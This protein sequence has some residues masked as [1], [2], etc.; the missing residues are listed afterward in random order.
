MTAID[1]APM[2][3]R[4]DF[5]F[6]PQKNWMNDPN[7]LVYFE[8]EYHLFFQ[9]NPHGKDWGHMSWG[10]AVS[11][12]LVYWQELPIAMPERE[13]MIFSGSVVV[14]WSNSSGLGDGSAPP[15][16]A[17]YTAYWQTSE[18]QSQHLAYSHDRG[19]TWIEYPGNPVLCLEMEHFRDPKV[20]W[21]APSDAWVLVVALSREHKVQV[22]RSTDLIVWDLASEF[23]PAGSTS[24]QWECPDLIEVPIE[25]TSE[26]A[27]A[28][29]VDVDKDLV[30]GGSGA[31]VFAGAFDGYNFTPFPGQ[32]A[33][34]VDLGPDFYAAQSWSD[35][36]EGTSHPI[37]IGWMSN[38]LTGKDYPTHPWRGAMTLPRELY[39]KME[40]QLVLAQRPA[41]LARRS[42][43]EHAIIGTLAG[44]QRLLLDRDD[45]PFLGQIVFT[46]G[47]R[48]HGTLSLAVAGDDDS[49]IQIALDFDARE[50]RLRRGR[51][52]ALPAD[53][54]A[55]ASASAMPPGDE[56]S[57]RII[58]DRS[59]LEVFVNDGARV[60]TACYFPMGKARTELTTDDGALIV[61]MSPVDDGAYAEPILTENPV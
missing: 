19:R 35:L 50:I 25:G 18:R 57:L 38:H 33:Q 40:Q 36:P 48:T 41:C 45:A 6:T 11:T 7:G 13:F 44:G 14:D 23:G 42:L 8:G 53:A 34:I 32:E 29:K 9:Y 54:F 39:F 1:P 47:A 5:H 24:G 49:G 20:F 2:D 31:Q 26:T 12:D 28:L 59:S 16:V 15:L 30:C 10:H 55:A 22:Y 43:P 4:P 58:I 3:Y 46:V 37:W 56:F 27:W 17:L 51:H 60:L 52:P 61:F 21:H